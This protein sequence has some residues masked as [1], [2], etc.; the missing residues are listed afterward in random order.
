MPTIE[1]KA[2]TRLGPWAVMVTPARRITAPI[3]APRTRLPNTHEDPRAKADRRMRRE[4]GWAN[5][6]PPCQ[7]MPP[8]VAAP[9]RFLEFDNPRSARMNS[10]PA[11]EVQQ[12]GQCL[13]S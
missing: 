13:H 8:Q 4:R 7:P 10:T 11:N 6:D 1:W 3:G 2:A 12:R 5:R 9:A